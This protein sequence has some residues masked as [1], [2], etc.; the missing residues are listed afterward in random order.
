MNASRLEHL[1]NTTKADFVRGEWSLLRQ[2]NDQYRKIIFNAQMY[3]ATGATYEQAVDMAT[4]DFL[5][6]GIQSITYKNGARHNI[7]DYS[8]MAIRTGQKRAYLMGEGD[9]HDKYG[10]HTVRVNKRTDACPLCVKWLGR[11]L[12]DDVYAGGTAEEA[13][14]AGVPLL[15]EAIDEGFLHP[16]CK[17]I[18]SLYIEGVSEKAKPWTKKE[19]EEIADRYNN[20]QALQRAEDMRDSY[21]RMARNSLDPINQDRYQARADAWTNR[22]DELKAGEPITPIIPTPP[23][24][25]PVAEPAPKNVASQATNSV[26]GQELIDYC[27]AVGVEYR[28]AEPIKNFVFDDAKT[29]SKISGGDRT[30]GSCVSLAMT[31]IGNMLGFDVRDFRGGKS[32]K[33]FS[34]HMNNK[35]LCNLDGVNAVVEHEFSAL[36]GAKA[37]MSTMEEDKIYMLCTGRHASIVRKVQPTEKNPKGYQFLELQSQDGSGWKNF[38]NTERGYNTDTT[39]RRRFGCTKSRT[40]LGTKIQQESYL[41]EA[42]SLRGN[43]EFRR[44]LGYINTE[45]SKEMKGVGGSAK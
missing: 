19:M 6:A 38:D 41:I 13:Q 42:E 12:V 21:D 5:K 10:I 20:E 3:S 25:E 2:A 28:E 15:S 27:K 24:S 40:V 43:E 16:N 23:K 17:D 9:V 31:Y 36:K 22:V 1:I 34:L 44:L 33:A 32:M 35:K 37:C 45:K 39:L 29:I 18:Y 8:R 30:Q 26:A 4:K 11:V 14:K 7:A